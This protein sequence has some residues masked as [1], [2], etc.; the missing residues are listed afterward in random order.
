[1]ACVIGLLTRNRLACGLWTAT[2]GKWLVFECE[3]GTGA[4]LEGVLAKV[5]LTKTNSLAWTF[6]V[7]ACGVA[8]YGSDSGL[9]LLFWFE[10][11][12]KLSWREYL[13]SIVCFHILQ[14]KVTRNEDGCP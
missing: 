7:Q 2:V 13:Y 12:K 9:F 10:S 11:I 1:M 3:S 5:R 8:G 4:P 14:I 6:A